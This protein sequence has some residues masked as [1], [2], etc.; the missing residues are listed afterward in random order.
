MN[1]DGVLRIAIDY[2][3]FPIGPGAVYPAPICLALSWR[4][5]SKKV[6][7]HLVSNGDG[8]AWEATHEGLFSWLEEDPRHEVVSHNGHGFDIPVCAIHKPVYIPRI[9]RA[10]ERGQFRETITREKLLNLAKFGVVDYFFTPDGK[11]QE[12]RYNLNAMALKWLGI[13]R[14]AVKGLNQKGKKEF[15]SW[16]MHFDTL[17]G[18]PSKDYP[19]EAIDYVLDD[20][21]DPLIICERQDEHA[22]E[23]F[24]QHGAIGHDGQ[25]FDVFRT[26]PLHVAAMFCLSLATHEGFRVDPLEVDKMEVE[27]A[28]AR[29]PEQTELLFTSGLRTRPLGIRPWK[30]GVRHGKGGDKPCTCAAT[31]HAPGVPKLLHPEDSHLST[32]RLRELA[33]KVWAANRVCDEDGCPLRGNERCDKHGLPPLKMTEPSD[34]FPGGQISCDAE[35]IEDLA[36]FDKVLDQHLHW[37]VVDKI[38]TIEIPRLRWAQAHGST[39]H[40]G[41]D[42]FKKTSRVSSRRSKLFPSINIQQ[43]PR[44]IEVEEMGPDCKPLPKLGKDGQP[45]I[46]PKTG[47]PVPKTIKIEP[48]HAYLPRTPGWVLVSIDYSFIELVTLAWQ[49][50]RVIGYSVLLDKINKGFDP[51]AFLG[52]QLAAGLESDFAECLRVLGYNDPDGIYVFFESL[53]GGS[54]E[55]KKFYKQWRTFAKPTGL[56]YPG[57]LGVRTFIIYAKKL[58]G[59]LIK[60]IDQ[61]K[62]FKEVWASAFPEIRVYLNQYIRDNLRGD[63]HSDPSSKER[64]AYAYFS[65][66]GAY[67]NRCSYT[68]VANGFSLQTP[69]AEGMKLALVR[70]QRACWDPTQNSMLYGC[71]I[72]AAIHDELLISMP[73]DAYLHERAFEASRLW[74]EGMNAICEGVLVKAEPAAMVRWDKS[75][76]AVYGP[77][78]RLR[79]WSP[80]EKYTV[81]AKGRLRSKT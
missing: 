77:D 79:V 80:D 40:G 7:T 36:S 18:I 25:P 51:H 70:V 23:V 74:I 59:I 29:R 72:P 55:E 19:Q 56:G 26:E 37:T 16:Q 54:P 50:K 2:E 5:V 45:I 52:A 61:A 38:D 47:E 41:F 78:E 15:T 3:T 31:S 67:R 60:S 22:N 46:D 68:E 44:G 64:H 10:L 34:K 62:Q 24:T 21:A 28:K 65:P 17:N 30:N 71:R 12:I 33:V 48:R 57:G 42:E 39:I 1:L 14:S 81:D 43:I 69:A 58:Y 6:V 35:V 76:E 63:G 32:T 27:V 20:A 9:F 8:D 53:K 4:D 13:D 11:A 73:N 75:A 49:M 66:L